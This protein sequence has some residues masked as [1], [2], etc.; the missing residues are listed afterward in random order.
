[1]TTHAKLGASSANRWMNCPGS[2]RM[3]D[4]LP[5]QLRERRSNFYADQGTAAHA[6]GEQCL[7]HNKRAEYFE[8]VKIHVDPATGNVAFAVNE[9]D[10]TSLGASELFEVDADMTD[11]VQ[12]YLDEVD[13][14]RRRL[15]HAE[16][17]VEESL[18]LS[19]LRPEMFGTSDYTR[20]EHFG[21]LIV[22]DYKHG[23]GIV[24]DVEWNAQMMYYGLGSL[25][26]AGGPGDVSQ[27]TLVI[28]QPR[29]LHKDGPVRR[30]SL[31]SEALWEWRNQLAEAAD[32]TRAPDA[33]LAAGDWC[34]FCPAQPL[35]PA[36]KGFVTKEAQ[37]VFSESPLDPKEHMPPMPDM[38][39]V[40][41]A[42]NAIP[43]IDA[44][45]RSVE[46]LGQEML[47]RG[48][49]VEN[50]KLVRKRANRKWTDTEK[51]MRALSRVKGLKK[52]DYTK[53]PALLSPAQMEKLPEVGKDFVSKH[54][55]K[56]EGG[57]TV[58]HIS[59][60]RTEVEAPAK[61]AFTSVPQPDPV[62]TLTEGG[63]D[64]VDL[65]PFL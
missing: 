47:E 27:V 14:Q 8:G 35:C 58:A 21:E 25:H 59:D 4:S 3:I 37:V 1:M 9:E 55:E 54:S 63:E 39:Q 31:S 32:K 10:F 60:R 20:R 36:I 30:W 51:T 56:P 19:W 46:G 24:V 26:N 43:V 64:L 65:I 28:V 45:C 53:E 11:A 22:S 2:I 44:W 6:L 41:R 12:V 42:L 52:K 62:A 23:K 13:A 48:L 38:D 57:L 5:T 7:A 50:Y 61:Q 17:N 40:G 29:A 15:P 49:V 34:R 16:E 18:D 33:P